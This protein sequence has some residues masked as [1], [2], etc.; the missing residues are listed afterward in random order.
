MDSKLMSWPILAVFGLSWLLGLWLAVVPAH[1]Q[2]SLARL[3]RL[4]SLIQAPALLRAIGAIWVVL[5]LA[6]F[7][8]NWRA[9]PGK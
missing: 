7:W 9:Y 4:D 5:L 2:L 3:I 6:M 8:I 1:S